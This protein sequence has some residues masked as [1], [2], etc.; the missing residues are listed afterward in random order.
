M[1]AELTDRFT[2]TDAEREALPTDGEVAEYAARGWY[3]SRKLFTDD[4]IDTLVEATERFYAGH[5][6]RRLPVRPPNLAYWTPER[7]DVQR[8]NDYVHYENDEIAAI[9]RKPL[10]GAVAARLARAEEIRVWQST[11]IYK[12]PR[13]GEPSNQ[14]PWHMDRHY[15]QTCT[16]DRMLTAFL[17]LHDC[18]TRMG[19]IT[20]VDGSHRWAEIPGD[21]STRHFAQRDK[22]EL[23]EL[24]VANAEHNGATVEKLPMVIPKGHVSFHHCRTYH[25]SGAN[26]AELPRRAVSLHLQDGDNRYRPFVKPDGSPVVYNHDVLVRRNSEGH[27]DYTDPEYCPV[28]WRE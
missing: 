21:D 22:A 24:L 17:P 5:T 2:L 3:L 8:H 15:W 7:G 27:P 23:E 9:L 4:E 19:T 11:L 16:S 20:M 28:L 6:D 12:P 10:L 26:L 18:D 14:V 1:T 25:G 13:P